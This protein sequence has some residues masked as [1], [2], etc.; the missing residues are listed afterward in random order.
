[1]QVEVEG[2]KKS[3]VAPLWLI[4]FSI[5]WELPPGQAGVLSDSREILRLGFDYLLNS[6]PPASCPHG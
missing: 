4:C 1:M 2:R 3:S 6:L 5:N